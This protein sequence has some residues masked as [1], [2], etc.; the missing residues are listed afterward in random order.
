MTDTWKSLVLSENF[1]AAED[2]SLHEFLL[3]NEGSA[4]RID[5][6]PLRR[7]DTVLIE[8]LLCAAATWAR[9]GRPFEVINLSGTNAEVMTTLGLTANNL[10][11]RVAA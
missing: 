5:A 9:A 3:G 2:G 4:V 8:L 1:R 10:N 11:W 7:L 6:G